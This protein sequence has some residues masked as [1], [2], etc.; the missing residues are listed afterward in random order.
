MNACPIH[1]G[2]KQSWQCIMTS[3]TNDEVENLISDYEK[4]PSITYIQI[5]ISWL[6]NTPYTFM[7]KTKLTMYYYVINEWWGHKSEF[8]LLKGIVDNLKRD[9]NILTF[10]YSP[11]HLW[12]KQSWQCIMTSST[13]D[14]VTNLISKM[15]GDRG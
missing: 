14:E 9:Y 10:E 6:L 13:K 4:G 15:T 2:G 3:S 12:S 11:I 8:R 1:L 7:V 5:I